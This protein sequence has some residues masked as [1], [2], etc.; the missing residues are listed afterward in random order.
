MLARIDDLI[1]KIE[2]ALLI[3]VF[4]T[5]ILFMTYSIIERNVFGHSS[6]M[7]QEHMPTLVAWI[8]LLGASLGLKQ[9]KHIRM[10]LS[11]RFLPQPIQRV[12]HRFGGAFAALIMGLGLYLCWNFM[13]NELKIF[14]SRGY[15]SLIFPIFFALATF[16]FMLQ[17][18][19]PK[20]EASG[21]HQ[22]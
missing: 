3:A 11:L 14:G 21:G 5:L 1:E 2:R 15:L 16:R 6:Q 20:A 12:M 22:P 17:V 8:S 9:G 19:R 10:E 7:V 18:V 4:S 13:S